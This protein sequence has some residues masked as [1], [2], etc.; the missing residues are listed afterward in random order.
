MQACWFWCAE[1]CVW[2]ALPWLHS[3]AFLG[4]GRPLVLLC[5]YL[6]YFP[7]MAWGHAFQHGKQFALEDITSCLP[8]Y[9]ALGLTLKS[10]EAPC[11]I[12][13]CSNLVLLMSE[14]KNASSWIL[15][16]TY[17]TSRTSKRLFLMRC[18]VHI[19]LLSKA[20]S[21][22]LMKGAI[23]SETIVHMGC[24]GISVLESNE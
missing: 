13:A 8:R 20:L 16:R 1:R 24:W 23:I 7:I 21:D 12:S 10:P 15:R 18:R 9:C 4:I 5:Q 3:P 2:R 14:I 6:V 19:T 22:S 11:S 17:F